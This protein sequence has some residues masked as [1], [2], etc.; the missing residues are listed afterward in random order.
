MTEPENLNSRVADLE[1]GLA[2]RSQTDRWLRGCV[3]LIA[4]VLCVLTSWQLSLIN[5][6]LT[7]QESHDKEHLFWSLCHVNSTAEARAA[8]FLALVQEGNTEWRS[9][10]LT[11]LGLEG[12]DL[13]GA[14][15]KYANFESSDFSSASLQEAQLANASFQLA[16]LKNANLTSAS[17]PSVYMIKADLTGANLRAA[18]LT[19]ASLEQCTARDA[20]FILANLS[21]ADLLMADLTDSNL[22][23]AKLMGANLEAAILRGTDLALANLANANLTNTDLTDSS[24]WRTRGLTSDQIAQFAKQFAPTQNADESRRNDF[25]RWLKAYAGSS[26]SGNR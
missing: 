9:A 12:V 6:H 2:R 23:G 5:K 19:S 18:D 21:E 13:N 24:W 14:D 25:A 3:L 11:G 16:N 8:A 15:L 1:K 4:L 22:T 26:P 20:I 17:L 7:R 10:R